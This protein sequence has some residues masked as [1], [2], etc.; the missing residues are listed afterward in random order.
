MFIDST[1]SWKIFVLN[2]YHVLA[3]AVMKIKTAVTQGTYYRLHVTLH[4]LSNL[5]FFCVTCGDSTP[6]QIRKRKMS[7]QL[8]G[9]M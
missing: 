7:N 4:I 3:M 2:T 1:A 8:L 9:K 5:V 6:I